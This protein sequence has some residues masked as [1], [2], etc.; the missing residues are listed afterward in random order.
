[1]NDELKQDMTVTEYNELAKAFNSM[2]GK[3]KENIAEL[4]AAQLKYFGKEWYV[5]K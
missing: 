4:K 5:W 2:L 1:M 3:Y